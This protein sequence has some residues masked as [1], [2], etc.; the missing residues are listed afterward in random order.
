MG[1]AAHGGRA[2]AQGDDAYKTLSSRSVLLVL[3]FPLENVSSAIYFWFFFPQVFVYVRF[4]A[5]RSRMGGV[6]S[7]PRLD[8]P[9]NG[10]PI[11]LCTRIIVLG[12]KNI[13]C[14]IAY[15]FVRAAA[16]AAVVNI[17]FTFPRRVTGR[18]REEHNV[19][20]RVYRGG[21]S[22]RLEH[23]CSFAVITQL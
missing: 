15:L 1:E 12:R 9:R 23:G 17:Y 8:R 16:A 3:F 13:Y 18:V 4:R 14:I 22:A 19:Y 5:S 10:H 6:G 21:S 7:D 2:S 11:P 20:F